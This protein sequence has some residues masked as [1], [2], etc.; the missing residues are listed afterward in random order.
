M[1]YSAHDTQII[2][3][4]D[5]LK[6]VDHEYIDATYVSTI[7]FEL[8][9]DTDCLVASPKSLACFNVHMIHN[10]V[11]L[12]LDTCIDANN[13]RNSGSILCQYDDFLA[14]IDKIKYKDDFNKTCFDP[15]TPPKLNQ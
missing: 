5:W 6:P 12:K 3:V 4:L 8:F 11:P 14:H 15:F 7:Y 9:Y 10:G 1:I 13:K 2:N